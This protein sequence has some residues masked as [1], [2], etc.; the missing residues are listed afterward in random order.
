MISLH[1]ESKQEQSLVKTL[2]LLEKVL[3]QVTKNY[4]KEK[5]SIILKIAYYRQLLKNAD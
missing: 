4:E 2:A 3:D 1:T 5:E